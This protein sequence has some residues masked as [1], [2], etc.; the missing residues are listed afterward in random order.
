MRKRIHDEIV[1]FRAPSAL[2]AEARDEAERRYMSISEFL[3]QAALH[4][5]ENGT[6]HQAQERERA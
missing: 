5:I 4:Q 3:R 2:I 6:K 1:R